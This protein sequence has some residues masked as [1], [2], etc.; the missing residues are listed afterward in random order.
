VP[1]FVERAAEAKAGWAAATSPRGSIAQP[2]PYVADD[3][4]RERREWVFLQE[5]PPHHVKPPGLEVLA[6]D[7]CLVV[8]AGVLGCPVPEIVHSK[9]RKATAADRTEQLA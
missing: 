9:E 6:P 7:T 1:R 4:A 5:L 3:G 8:A 2:G